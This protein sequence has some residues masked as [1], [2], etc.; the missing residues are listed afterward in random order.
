MIKD[1][2]F[3]LPVGSLLLW[4]IFYAR[5]KSRYM[6]KHPEKY[7]IQDRYDFGMKVIEKIK[8]RARIETLVFG[9]E[10]VPEDETVVFYANHQGKYD[11]LGI[12]GSMNNVPSSVL[13]EER[14][15][16]RFLAHEMSFLVNAVLI[17]LE[18][19]KGKAKGIIDAIVMIKSG[20]NMLIFPEGRTNP[21][22]GNA[23]GEFQSGCFACS[24]KTGTTIVPVT[25]WDSYKAMNGNRIFDHVTTQVH[26]LRSILYEEYKD[27]SKQE[28]S[29]LIR[30]RIAEKLDE[31]G[32]GRFFT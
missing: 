1:L 14:R 25:I 31:I 6:M 32:N 27:M 11:A 22:K 18:S 20:S 29:E 30:S 5:I 9:R 24:L 12:L 10:N 16:N 3:D 4:C 19:M 21:V 23:L 7:S 28:L 17:D 2:R 13:W 8:K 26:F 15:A